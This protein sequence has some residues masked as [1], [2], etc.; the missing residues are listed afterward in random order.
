MCIVNHTK[1]TNPSYAFD[2]SMSSIAPDSIFTR[3]L[4]NHREVELEPDQILA[5]LDLCAEY[6]ERALQIRLE[7]A[8]I[9]E[10]LDIRDWDFDDHHMDEIARLLRRH[11]RLFEQ[12]EML[13]FEYGRKG[14]AILSEQQLALAIEVYKREER[15]TFDVFGPLVKRALRMIDEEARDDSRPLLDMTG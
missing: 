1:G 10:E 12:H 6:H 4:M 5:I 9:R 8:A 13:L 3:L 15:R 7:F 11:S 2:F 14:R